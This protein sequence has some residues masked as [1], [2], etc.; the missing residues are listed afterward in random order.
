MH[1]TK[2]SVVIPH[3]SGVGAEDLLINCIESLS[4]SGA[5]EVIPSISEASFAINSNI[6]LQEA[7]GEFIILANNDTWVKKGNLKDLCWP[8]GITVP[9]IIP[10]SRDSNPRCF[11]CMPRWVYEWFLLKDEYFYDERFTGYY[12]DDDLIRRCERDRIKIQVRP[13]VIIEHLNGGGFTIK[14]LGEQEHFDFNQKV[15][16]EKWS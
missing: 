14:Q 12:E 9:A 10:P 15:F 6:G 7:S 13:Q 1:S 16:A 2:I 11:F 3:L 4:N 8:L 5:N